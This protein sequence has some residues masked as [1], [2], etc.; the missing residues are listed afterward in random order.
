MG[1]SR[2]RR[3]TEGR[4]AR[5]R[6]RVARW[7]LANS[8]TLREEC[9]R[10]PPGEDPGLLGEGLEAG[11]RWR[12][13]RA[14]LDGE[15]ANAWRWFA[16][17]ARPAPLTCHQGT[18]EA[19]PGRSE[20]RVGICCSGG[21]IRSAAFNLGALQ[22]LEDAG[23]RLSSATYLSAVSGGSYIAAAMTRAERDRPAD[24]PHAF[25]ARTPEEQYLRNRSDYLAPSAFGKLYLGYRLLLGFLFNA[26]FVLLPVIVGTILLSLWLYDPRADANG[27]DIEPAWWWIAGGLAVASAAVALAGMV[28]R[29]GGLRLQQFSE[30]WSVRLVV[31]AVVVGWFLIGIPAIDGVDEFGFGDAVPALAGWAGLLAGIGAAVRNALVRPSEAIGSGVKAVGWFKKLGR[32]TRAT[33]IY[34]GAAVAGPVFVGAVTLATASL[35]VDASDTTALIVAGGAATAFVLA[36]VFGDMTRWSLHPFYKRRLA[37]AFALRRVRDSDGTLRAEERDY[38]QPIPLS[39]AVVKDRQWPTLIVCAAA[40]VSDPGATPPGRR[41]TS[42]T[43]S[44]YAIG[45]PLV[46]GVPTAIFERAFDGDRCARDVTLLA[47]VAMSGAAVA[48]SMGKMSRRSLTFLMALANVRLGV[49]VPNP[50]W[51]MRSTRAGRRAFGRARPIYLYRELLGRNRVDGRYLFV[52][53]GGHYENLGLVELLRRGC[54]H[55]YCFDASGGDPMCQLG[56]AIALARSE[57]GVE[58]EIDPADLRSRPLAGAGGG[59]SG[60]DSID[61]P[62]VAAKDAVRGTISYPNGRVGTLVYATNVVTSESPWDVHAHRQGNTDFPRNSTADQL[63]T[64]QRFESY[65]VLG[66][67]AAG[68]AIALM[69]R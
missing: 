46:G 21:G 68:T 38:D 7:L 6:S 43:F 55:V 26:A 59:G 1:A 14:G 50:G 2:G 27:I 16:Y 36:Y 67:R 13:W 48:P 61:V 57:L 62:E 47:A 42:F 20:R 28:S 33:L 18:I 45:G 39:K 52:T 8:R 22:R 54:T 23:G 51:V 66:N 12:R 25:A 24:G 30:T 64:D 69:D 35:A 4:R 63:Y 37:S 3:A 19:P 29:L 10:P 11:E 9:G 40:N 56:D 53:D 32:G 49:W 17:G 5:W 31:L 34:A 15:L 41:V 65:R 58:I 60:D 44:P